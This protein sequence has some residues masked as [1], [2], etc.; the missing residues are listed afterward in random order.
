M[1]SLHCATEPRPT[2]V[3]AQLYSLSYF[4]VVLVDL[5]V[6]VCV[7]TLLDSLLYGFIYRVNVQSLHVST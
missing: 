6:C 1:D 3:A 4:D 2:Y 5:S 7:H